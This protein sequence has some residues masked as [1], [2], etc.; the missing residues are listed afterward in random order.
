LN[1]DKYC[2]ITNDVETTSLWNHCLSDKTGEIVFK[3][4]M[5]ILLDA[6]KK[7][8]IKA[9][10]FFTGHIARL[11]PDIVR[12]VIPYGHEVACHGLTHEPDK[13]FDV[14]T[15]DEQIDHLKKAKDIL[16]DICSQNVISFRAPALRVNKYTPQ[17]LVKAGFKIDSSVAPQRLDMFLSFGSVEK[18]K[19]IFAPRSPYFTKDNNLAKR[20][21]SPVF[22]I[23]LTSVFLP[24]AGTIMRVSPLTAKFVRYA[25]NI[26][27][28]VKARPMVFIIHPNELIDE[29]IE[30][31][32]ADRRT[33]NYLA[34]LLG[35]KL[36]YRLKLKNL[37]KK[38]L[39]LLVDQLEFAKR[40]NYKYVT[41]REFY[42]IKGLK[43]N[44]AVS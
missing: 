8:N 19:W 38:A 28:S 33:R 13:A 16:E 6:Y 14:L 10:F 21:D 17:A 41:C 37:G 35:D 12:M 2:L 27:A 30:I 25:L 26:E 11:F 7:Y 34:F 5:P 40:E 29:K 23:P 44:E 4:G 20:G 18:M 32:T 22:E 3:E 39:P 15:L 1:K 43:Y 42:E 9:T 24:W 36:R 31:T